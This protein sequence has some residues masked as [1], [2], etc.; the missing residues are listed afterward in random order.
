VDES[1]AVIS[2]ETDAVF[3][4]MEYDVDTFAEIVSVRA[5]SVKL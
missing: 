2:G 1:V 5:D 4:L 3:S